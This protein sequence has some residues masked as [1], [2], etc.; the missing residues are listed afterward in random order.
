M[1]SSVFPASASGITVAEGTAAGWGATAGAINWTQISHST[2][3][4]TAVNLTG[5]G[6][7]K[8]YRVVFSGITT[9]GTCSI[10]LRL[11]NNSSSDYFWYGL[12]YN[13]NASGVANG[14]QSNGIIVGLYNTATG[15]ATNSDILV[16]NPS[17]STGNKTVKAAYYYYD[18]PGNY[19]V[20][21]LTGMVVESGITQINLIPLGSSFNGGTVTL[22][23]GN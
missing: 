4:G 15:V 19:C 8:Y 3:S 6:S 7:Y 21:N 18:S 1:G 14:R 10:R 11:N 16:E 17:S 13:A 20:D 2:A 5:L 12:A 23:G 9:A 22:Y